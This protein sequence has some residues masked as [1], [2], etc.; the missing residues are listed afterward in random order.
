MA[1]H[2]VQRFVSDRVQ[3]ETIAGYWIQSKHTLSLV[4]FYLS[5]V[6]LYIVIIIPIFSIWLAHIALFA[7]Y[8]F[9]SVL[10]LS[11]ILFSSSIRA[12]RVVCFVIF[13]FIK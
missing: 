5:F 13:R 4:L 2:N 7:I 9:L 3:K 11:I 10:F 8:V 6:V 12:K 1:A